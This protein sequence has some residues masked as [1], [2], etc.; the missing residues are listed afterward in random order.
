MARVWALLC[1]LLCFCVGCA[2][3]KI[4]GVFGKDDDNTIALKGA[5]KILDVNRFT[6]CNG[7]KK[8]YDK[9][10]AQVLAANTDDIDIKQVINSSYALRSYMVCF[11]TALLTISA[12]L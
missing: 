5:R 7:I 1:A 8:N 3:G 9:L 12:C 10:T 2:S 4:L 6:K 11:C